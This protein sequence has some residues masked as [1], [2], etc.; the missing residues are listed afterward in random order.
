MPP[1]ALL[2]KRQTIIYI[3]PSAPYLPDAKQHRIRNSAHSSINYQYDSNTTTSCAF[4]RCLWDVC[5]PKTDSSYRAMESGS[6]SIGIG[7]V[8]D[9]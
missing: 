8:V 3:C 9:Q 2:E 1:L 7:R 4:L 6:G 5:C